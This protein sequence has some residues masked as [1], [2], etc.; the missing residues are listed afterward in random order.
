LQGNSLGEIQHRIIFLCPKYWNEKTPDGYREWLCAID[1]SLDGKVEESNYHVPE[2]LKIFEHIKRDVLTPDERTDLIEEY[3][4]EE[5]L[6]RKV[7]KAMLAVGLSE[8]LICKVT[9]LT[10]AQLQNLPETYDE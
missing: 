7:A 8:E 10:P 9:E 6:S 1:D 4:L 5:K 2:I 3:H